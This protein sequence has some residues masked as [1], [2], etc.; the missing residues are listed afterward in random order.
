MTHKPQMGI[1]FI[2][3]NVN[4][5]S[6]LSFGIFLHLI[7]NGHF[8]SFYCFHNISAIDCNA[9]RFW[10]IRF[11]Q[12]KNEGRP[13]GLIFRPHHKSHTFYRT[14]SYSILLPVTHRTPCTLHTCVVVTRCHSFVETDWMRC[15]QFENRCG[16]TKRQYK[17]QDD[18]FGRQ[19]SAVWCCIWAAWMDWMPKTR[20]I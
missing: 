9:Y 5:K 3:R 10:C 8:I 14:I 6:Q 13:S 15:F 16:S 2:F 19:T 17:Y 7:R 20:E 11:Q 18:A 12:C 1:V 4:R